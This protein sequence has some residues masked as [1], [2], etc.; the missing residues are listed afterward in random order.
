MWRWVEDVGRSGK[1]GE[2]PCKDSVFAQKKATGIWT[3]QI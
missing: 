2:S 3:I 1:I